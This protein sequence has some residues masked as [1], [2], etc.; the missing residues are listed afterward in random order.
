VNTCRF[1]RCRASFRAIRVTARYC[2]TRCRIA[3][4]RGRQRTQKL[5]ACAVE[6]IERAEA[7]ALIL[8]HEHLGTTGRV[9]I[10]F[11]LRDPTGRIL[12]LCGF[13][14][15][16]HD[17]GVGVDAVLERGWTARRAP[18][19]AS[20]FLIARAPL[21]WGQRHLSWRLVKAYSDIRF[22][23][24]GLV[25]RATGFKPCPPSRHGSWGYR[26]A[27][28]ECGEVLSDRAIYRRHG[29]HAAARAAG[30]TIVR[31]PERKAWNWRLSTSS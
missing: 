18:H 23:E 22:G 3:S 31:V 5:R 14:A 10:W 2:S 16:P 9:G 29:S 6:R 11:G 20:S 1:H 13:G 25:Y 28:V 8:K 24:H 17:G 27:L 21:R 26:Y 7:R 15:G 12:S 19:N 4:H 30:A